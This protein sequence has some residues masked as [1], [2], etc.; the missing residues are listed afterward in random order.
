MDKMYVI[1]RRRTA[2][3][4]ILHHRTCAQDDR[5]IDRSEVLDA[6]RTVNKK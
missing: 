5:S 1:G 4:L 3:G 6:V 2:R